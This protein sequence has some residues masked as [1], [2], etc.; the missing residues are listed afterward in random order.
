MQS[1]CWRVFN[2]YGATAGDMCNTLINRDVAD[3]DVRKVKQVMSAADMESKRGALSIA[4]MYPDTDK[5][6]ADK[7]RELVNYLGT[8]TKKEQK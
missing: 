5:D 4:D 3:G 6:K 1:E 7:Y 8:D 2:N